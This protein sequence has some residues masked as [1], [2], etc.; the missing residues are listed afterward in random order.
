[1]ITDIKVITENGYSAFIDIGGKKY[2]DEIRNSAENIHKIIHSKIIGASWVFNNKEVKI[3][4]EDKI[5]ILYPSVDRQYIVVIYSFVDF[6]FNNIITKYPP[7]YNAIIYNANGSIHKKLCVPPLISDAAKKRGFYQTQ[8]DEILGFTKVE[9]GK[10]NSDNLA[11]IMEISE[12]PY[13]I[14][15]EYRILDPKTGT[16][17]ECVNSKIA[18]K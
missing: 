15:Q 1:M 16:F 10:D 2:Y 6:L 5:S 8:A 7:P 3:Y 18:Y 14:L 13:Q 12:L 11:V 9:W 4:E 17:G